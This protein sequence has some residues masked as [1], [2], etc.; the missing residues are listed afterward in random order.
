[1]IKE[2]DRVVLAIDLPYEGP[3]EG[4]VGTVRGFGRWRDRRPPPRNPSRP[5][6]SI[7]KR[8]VEL[9]GLSTLRC[10]DFQW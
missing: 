3:A 10:S 7:A 4:D 8:N 5:Q 1:M 2:H 9:P 6:G